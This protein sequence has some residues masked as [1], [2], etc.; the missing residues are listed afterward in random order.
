[1]LIRVAR[2]E[3]APGIARVMVD[4]WLSHRGQVPEEVWTKTRQNWSYDDETCK[5]TGILQEIANGD[6]PG[7]C[8][9]VALDEAGEIVGHARGGPSD[10]EG[11]QNTGEIWSLY[12]RESHQRRGIGS[13]LVQAVA[14]HLAEMGMNSLLIGC[15]AAG[16][17]ARRFYEALGGRVVGQRGFDEDGVM[18][19]LVVYGW[20]DTRALVAMGRADR[21]LK[22]TA[23]P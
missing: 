6:T 4:T 5:W 2:V 18:L 22:Y 19:P 23:G 17:P 16:A 8:V 12:V 11:T 15:L 10:E 14:A 1:M 20:T 13:R 9:Y 21:V 7:E 3:D